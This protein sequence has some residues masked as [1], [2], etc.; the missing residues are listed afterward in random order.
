[1]TVEEPT[2]K[3]HYLVGVVSWGFKC[4]EVSTYLMPEI[5][6]IILDQGRISE[7]GG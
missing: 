7:G 6:P 5:Y 1:M 3:Q 2:T 4:A